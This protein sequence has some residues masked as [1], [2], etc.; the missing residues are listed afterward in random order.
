MFEPVS[1]ESVG[2]SARH[3]NRIDATMQAF[4]DQ[5]SIA[6]IVTLIARHGQVVHTGTY[7]QLDIAANKPI[8]TDSLFRVASF[9]KPITSVA[10]MMLLEEG[11]FQLDDPV[12]NW[13]PE[14]GH[15]KVMADN[16]DPQSRLVDLETEIT[17]WH[18]FTHTSGL[19]Y[20]FNPIPY[21]LIEAI[22][23]DAK[24]INPKQLALQFPLPTLM[25]KVAELP[26]AAQ[27]GVVWQ[28]GLNHEV[29]GYLIGLISGHPF[30]QFLR[31]RIFEPLGM[32]DTSFYV[33]EA[34]LDRFGP[35][36][37]PPNENGL[38]IL[39]EVATS[40]YIRPDVVPSGGGGLVSTLPDYFRFMLMFA[41][42]GELDGVRL[43]KPE[44]IAAMS[45]NQLT[46]SAFPIRF[47]APWNGMGFG[48]GM[49]VQV[50]EPIRFGW[51]GACGSTAW[52][53]PREDLIVIAIPQARNNFEASDALL[54]LACEAVDLR[55]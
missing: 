30:D 13:I 28:Y 51:I 5:G 42:G 53:Y 32:P 45:T 48:L 38:S 55:R 24:L 31:E 6:G 9:T 49:G 33:P 41:N 44:T 11:H 16:T 23:L 3:L 39:D 43:L 22:Y 54:R 18:L 35:M 19:G 7:G 37:G 12:S 8:Q 17:F 50:T 40:P 10:A 46:G 25:Q 2:M 20:G 4:V 36:Y 29:L 1:P 14:F 34:K 26:L 15:F 21:D 47:G 27:P 52:I